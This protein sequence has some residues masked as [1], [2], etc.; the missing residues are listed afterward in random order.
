MVFCCGKS[1]L[2]REDDEPPTKFSDVPV[3]LQEERTDV[4]V[5]DLAAEQQKTKFRGQWQRGNIDIKTAFPRGEYF[6][7]G[8]KPIYTCP[9]DFAFSKAGKEK[10]Q[11]LWRLKKPCYGLCDAPLGFY[12]SLADH[13]TNTL[14]FHKSKGPRRSACLFDAGCC[15][16]FF[17]RQCLKKQYMSLIHTWRVSCHVCHYR[18]KGQKVYAWGLAAVRGPT[19]HSVIVTCGSSCWL[20]S[21][22]QLSKTVDEQLDTLKQEEDVILQTTEGRVEVNASSNIIADQKNV[23]A[24]K[25][26]MPPLI[27]VFDD[28]KPVEVDGTDTKR[29]WQETPVA[30]AE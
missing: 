4:T 24:D 2:P 9:P 19:L 30:G 18:L 25:K 1:S 22:L 29:R 20:A 8:E 12:K 11:W 21:A 14:K 7:R 15:R 27:P 5:N 10:G 28:S 13:L 23:H 26:E 17:L 3:V 16:S 6:D